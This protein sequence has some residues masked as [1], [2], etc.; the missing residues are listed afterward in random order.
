MAGRKQPYWGESNVNMGRS[1]PRAWTCRCGHH[2]RAYLNQCWDCGE[3]RPREFAGRARLGIVN[4][5]SHKVNRETVT[6]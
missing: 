6:V 1:A 3:R 4:L 5:A 2:N